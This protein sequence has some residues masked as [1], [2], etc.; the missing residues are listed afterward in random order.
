MRRMT[1]VLALLLSIPAIANAPSPYVGLAQRPIRA[2]SDA[3]QA[4]L[5]SGRGMGLALAAE[6]NG[7][8]GPLHVL[9]LADRLGLTEAQREGSERLAAAMRERARAI[10]A[11]IVE[12]ERV[13]DALFRERRITE[14][15]L[16]ART[17]TIGML[18][19][20][21]RN[22]HLRTHIDQA[23]LLT[24]AQK[25]TYDHLRG[26]RG[27]PPAGSHGGQRQH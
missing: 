7:W 21:L 24:Q 11:R 19:G 6:L 27:G 4:D 18:Q 16:D 25:E 3:E 1:A 12:Q 26:Y 20:E 9:E 23:A 8:P 15:E 13:L 5:L 2:L 10:G 22:V 17:A 14:A